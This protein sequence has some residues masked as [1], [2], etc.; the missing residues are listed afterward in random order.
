[1]SILGGLSWWPSFL[2]HRTPQKFITF[3]GCSDTLKGPGEKKKDVQSHF[4]NSP[5]G[6]TKMVNVYMLPN[7]KRQCGWK[8]SVLTFPVFG[9]WSSSPEEWLWNSYSGTSFWWTECPSWLIWYWF[10]LYLGIQP[11]WGWSWKG[12]A[13]EGV[14]GGADSFG[15]WDAPSSVAAPISKEMW[16]AESGA[17]GRGQPPQSSSWKRLCQFQGAFWGG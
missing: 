14:S 9:S 17:G 12:H 5:N 1:M 6:A 3:A 15:F 10:G 16:W 2:R 11:T 7:S 4:S 13:T 8:P